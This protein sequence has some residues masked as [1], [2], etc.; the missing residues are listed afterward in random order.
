M[1]LSVFIRVYLRASAL[2][3]VNHLLLILLVAHG[4][5]NNSLP[6]IIEWI[7]KQGTHSV[8]K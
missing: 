6:R 8:I 3:F 5:L 7:P 2:L 1:D 4:C